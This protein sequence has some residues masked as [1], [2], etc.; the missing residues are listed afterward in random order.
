MD[1]ECDLYGWVI[2]D[3]KYIEHAITGCY[4]SKTERM[5]KF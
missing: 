2:Q 5:N 4:F 3:H 1:A